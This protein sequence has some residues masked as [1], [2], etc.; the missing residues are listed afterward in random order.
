MATLDSTW[1][2]ELENHEV[3]NQEG[4]SAFYEESLNLSEYSSGTSTFDS[5]CESDYDLPGP[6]LHIEDTPS[7]EGI[8]Y[9]STTTFSK[10]C[11]SSENNFNTVKARN[12]SFLSIK[13]E[14]KYVKSEFHYANLGSSR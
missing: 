10:S 12:S 3:T 2:C 6:A 14:E 7:P 1:L 8:L 11:I 13:S 4:E 5:D 9:N